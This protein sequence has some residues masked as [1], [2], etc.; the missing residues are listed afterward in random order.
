MTTTGYWVEVSWMD[1]DDD[2]DSTVRAIGPFRSRAAAEARAAI[3]G[4]RFAGPLA[5]IDDDLHG[6][7]VSARAAVRKFRSPED[8]EAEVIEW[9]EGFAADPE[10]GPVQP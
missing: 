1:L 2:G 3:L 7:M 5:A 4:R 10:P 8:V 9:L 6:G